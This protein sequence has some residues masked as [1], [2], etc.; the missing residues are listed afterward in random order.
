MARPLLSRGIHAFVLSESWEFGELVVACIEN[1]A[2]QQPRQTVQHTQRTWH[3]A[4]AYGAC[5]LPC[6]GSQFA[7][8][9]PLLAGLCPFYE[10]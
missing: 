4:S 9:V 8:L 2:Q 3:S 6:S 7:L 1:L 10:F 5:V